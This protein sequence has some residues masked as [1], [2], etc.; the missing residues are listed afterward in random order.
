MSLKQAN[1]LLALKT[2]LGADVLELASFT[3]RE[4]ISGLFL[5]E[6]EMISDNNAITASQIVGK[7]VT[8][9][10]RLA[11]GSPRHF[12]GFVSRFSA[13]NEDRQGRRNYRAEVVPWLWF[14]TRT[15]DCRIFQ[16]K[17]VPDIIQQVF[18]DLGFTDFQLNLKGK[19]PERDYC[20]QYRESD[21]AFVSRLMEEEGIFYFFKHEDGKHTMVVGDQKGA[22]FDCPEGDVEFPRDAG[23]RAVTDH[24]TRWEHRY[25]Y[26]SGKIAHTDY[27]FE[28]HPAR[29][30]PT[31]SKLMMA[32][33]STTVSLENIQKFELYEYPGAFAK[34]EDGD[35]LAKVRMEEEEAAYDVVEG[36]ATCRTF[37]VGGKF[38]VK[39]HWSKSEEGKKYV[40][41]V[42]E[43]SATEPAAYETGEEVADEYSNTFTCIPDSVTF[44]PQRT[45]PRP[46][47]AGTQPAVVVGPPGEE[48][49]PDKYGRVKIQFFWD[50]EGK[51]DDKSSCWVRCA[52]TIA[53]KGWGAV[54]IPRIGQEVVVSFFEGDPDRPLITGVVYN[55][56]QMPPYALPDKKTQCGI[57]S[58]ST[59]GG[60]G[61][62]EIRMDDTKGK[63]QVFVHAQYNQDIEV[64]N[65][66]TIKIGNNRTETVGKDESITIGANRTEKV[67]KDENI[68]IAGNRTEMVNKDE[69]ITIAGN[70]TETIGKK[71][72]ITAAD[73][74][75]IKV[76]MA[77]ITMKKDGTVTIKGKDIMIEGSGKITGKA[78]MLLTLKGKQILLN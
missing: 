34:K 15:T 42:I 50:R 37:A 54:L 66:E 6:L 60:G 67:G 48:I 12:N 73:E 62:N 74:L 63:E 7:N 35:S 9:A 5:Y 49:Y 70:R 23:T 10:V 58:N 2:P 16:K 78:S 76:G 11:D 44:R 30:E 14:L 57:K 3:G 75:S 26:R 38:K 46:T 17:T 21:F 72:S 71:L 77:S 20:V 18:K 61:S 41:T 51:S 22:Y 59:K 52:Q 28:D 31:P 1:R 19:H 24:I 55:A 65:D 45:T 4:E 47:I 68:S 43:H 56:D 8:F 39:T 53:G 25:E 27:N 32:N 36:A 13:G 40:I 69:S 29:N 64:E 33:Q